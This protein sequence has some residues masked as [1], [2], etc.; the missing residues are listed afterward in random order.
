VA[1]GAGLEECLIHAQ[2]SESIACLKGIEHAASPGIQR[3]IVETDALS[4]TKAIGDPGSD[5]SLLS[6]MFREI[7]A[8][9]LCDFVATSVSH[10]PRACNSVAHTIAALGLN[11]VNG[12]VYWQDR[13]PNSCWCPTKC[14][15]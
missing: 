12:P 7:R 10:Y 4:V 1:A 13:L 11:C 2:Q 3:I 15:V 5:R 6:T 8:R 9:L 14:L